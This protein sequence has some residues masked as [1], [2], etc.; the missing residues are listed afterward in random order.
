MT[1]GLCRRCGAFG[2][3]DHGWVEGDCMLPHKNHSAATVGH[4]CAWHVE[5][6]QAWLGEIAELYDDLPDVVDEGSVPDDTAEHKH[7]KRP[8]S[9]ALMRL[10][11][12]SMVYEADDLWAA[13][14]VSADSRTWD[15]DGILGRNYLRGLPD[16]AAVMGSWA[17]GCVD[18][19]G[20]TFTVSRRV[21]ANA[22]LLKTNAEH[23]ATQ[24]WVD[25]Y[26]A[27]LGWL[28]RCL[29][30]AHGISDPEPLAPCIDV[31][32]GRECHGM[33]WPGQP[34]KCDRCARKYN[35]LDLVRL[36]KTAIDAKREA[37]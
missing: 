26:D 2:G 28:R 30:R 19:L 27:E 8:A 35:T 9:P 37:G 22:A 14:D 18:S 4:C 32:N 21:S 12:W 29:R 15:G 6:H 36:K 13:G 23:I 16:V 20:M 7:T 10:E 34:P 5:R 3:M 33:V 31:T 1:E 17:Q 11:A 24:A 25:D